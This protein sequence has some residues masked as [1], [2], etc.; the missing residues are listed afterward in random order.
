[1]TKMTWRNRNI[2]IDGIYSPRVEKKY[3]EPATRK[4]VGFFGNLVAYHEFIGERQIT[5]TFPA[6]CM[7]NT[8]KA[9]AKPLP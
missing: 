3:T 4:V 6:T 7:E 5:G 8:F 2:Q 9:W 1:M